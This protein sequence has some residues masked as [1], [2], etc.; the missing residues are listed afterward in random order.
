MVVEIFANFTFEVLGREKEM[1]RLGDST[2]TSGEL[3]EALMELG[4][5]TLKKFQYLAES[6]GAQQIVAVATSAVREAH[7]GGE[8]LQR[9]LKETR[10][11][12]RVITGEEEGR[13]IYLG[14]KNSMKLPSENSLIIDIG[15]GS[16]EMMVVTPEKVLFQD[17]LKLGV[18][19]LRSKFLQK[20]NKKSY[21]RMEK[22]IERKSRET[23]RN[24]LDLGFSQV[25]GTSGT[26]NTLATIIYFCKNP[27]ARSLTRQASFSF[28]DLKR[29]Y[30]RLQNSSEES[31]MEIRGLDPVRN[32]LILS[33][34]SLVYTL[35]RGL[36]IDQLTLCD[37]AI[38]EGMVYHFISKNHR[39]IRIEAEI[40]DVRRRSVLRLAQ[41]CNFDRAHGEQ[42]ARLALTLF[43]RIQSFHGLTS[44]DRELLEYAALLHDVGYLIGY[45][46]HHHH[47]YYL[48]KNSA[49]NGFSEEE[50]DLM[51]QL[52]LYHRRASP[53]KNELPY[54]LMPKA[55]QRR[56]KWLSAILKVAD[57]L[58]RSHFNV[59]EEL[60][61]RS[62]QDKIVMHLGTH[63]DSEYEIWEAQHRCKALKKLLR[64]PILFKN[65][66]LIRKNRVVLKNKVSPLGKIRAL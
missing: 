17:S 50:I 24:I 61:V 54:A 12:V 52:A 36:K 55:V 45:E 7:N 21:N 11:K 40:P 26:L 43:D 34:A 8:F 44:L 25:I 9:I 23:W 56:I 5:E 47:S 57:A 31:R 65:Q 66:P 42:V 18:A 30:E 63:H 20:E 58:D 51:A 28:E 35:M 3:S 13:L 2:F 10:I 16:V 39:K 6:K 37:K 4:L 64:R 27:Q 48:I 59:V 14:V 49:M 41:K 32:N 53:K 22:F 38:R 29:I 1:I 60:K 19:R 46:K 15:G 33:G 62:Y